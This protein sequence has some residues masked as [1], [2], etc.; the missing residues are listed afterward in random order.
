MKKFKKNLFLSTPNMSKKGTVATLCMVLMGLYFVVGCKSLAAQDK[1]TFTWQVNEE[2]PYYYISF[3]STVGEPFTINWGDG[4]I[5]TKVC[6]DSIYTMALEHV[7]ETGGKYT[8]TF[9]AANHN[10]RFKSFDSELCGILSFDLTG[11]SAL[12]SLTFDRNGLTSLDLTGCS[13]LTSLI[14]N[15]NALTDLDLSDCVSLRELICHKNKL[16]SLNLNSC[17]NM[18]RLNC[19]ENQLQLSDLYKIQLMEIATLKFGTQNISPQ[20]ANIGEALFSDQAI[21]NGVFTNY[22]VYKNSV[23][24][25]ESDYII[26]DGKLKFNA[27][28]EYTATMTNDAIVSDPDYPA[29]VIVDIVVDKTTVSESEMIDIQI[30]PNPTTGELRVTSY[31]LQVTSIEVFDIYG[32]AVSTHYSLL[33]THYSIN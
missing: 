15:G 7:Y 32:R 24:A 9:E 25:P 14:C 26:V 31:E 21:F 17:A 11:C 6:E 27:V 1:I 5:E 33:T 2:F 10:C 18:I 28:G 3:S 20:T 12:T 23:P 29:K 19:S 30:Y 13:A 16:T 4:N 22:V 8:V